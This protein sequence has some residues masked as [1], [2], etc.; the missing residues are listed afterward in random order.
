MK[1]KEA[2]HQFIETWGTL[3]TTWGISRTMAQIHALLLVADHPL[4]ADDII[5]QLQISRGN[6][7]MNTRALIDWGLVERKIKLGERGEYFVAEKDIWKVAMRIIRERRKREI[8]PLKKVLGQLKNV[9]D[10]AENK[11]E[12]NEYIKVVT[13]IEKFVDSADRITDKMNDADKNWFFSSL[14]KFVVK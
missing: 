5:E 13:D 4:S 9:E 11:A 8:D 3:G 6:A 1:L 10:K 2:K 7:N 12:Y 14:M